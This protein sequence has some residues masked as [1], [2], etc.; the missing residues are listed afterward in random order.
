M[1]EITAEYLASQGLSPSFPR[2]FWAKVNKTDSCWL[3]T[4]SKTTVGYGMIGIGF[5]FNRLIGAH[6]ASWI[7]HKG[8]IPDG[9]C[10]LH[11]CPGGDTPSCV[12][13]NHLWLGTKMDNFHDLMR[14]GRLVIGRRYHGEQHL[15]HKLT[16]DQVKEIRQRHNLG[17]VTAYALGREFRV[18]GE[19]IL[20]IVKRQIWKHII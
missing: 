7:L 13:P 19:N 11:N 6:R 17:G 12:N 10:V 8:P 3:W 9:L 18:T 20:A 2:R 1:I 4:A 5:G 15:K 16:S 14:K